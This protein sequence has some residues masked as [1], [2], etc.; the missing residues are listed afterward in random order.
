MAEPTW[1]ETLRN[2][3]VDRNARES[4]YSTII[5]QCMYWFPSRV[6]AFLSDE[7]LISIPCLLHANLDAEKTADWH[8]KLSYL[9]NAMRPSLGRWVMRVPILAAPRSSYQVPPKSEFY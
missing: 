9:R 8:S 1:Q 5:E 3:L 4:A 6:Y 2:R 7:I